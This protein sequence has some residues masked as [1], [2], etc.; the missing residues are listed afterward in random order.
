MDEHGMGD[1][2]EMR[3]KW[4]QMR[5]TRVLT[6]VIVI[7]FV[8]WCGFQFGEIRAEVGSHFGGMQ[9]MRGGWGGNV[10]YGGGTATMHTMIPVTGSTVSPAHQITPTGAAAQ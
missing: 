9:T 6:A 5:A 2:H 3:M 8:F 7:I 1:K 10:M 4:K